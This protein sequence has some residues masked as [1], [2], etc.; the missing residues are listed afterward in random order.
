MNAMI[1]ITKN[2][3]NEA[4]DEMFSSPEVKDGIRF[5]NV[6]KI[7]IGARLI[8]LEYNE[9]DQLRIRAF[10]R[11]EFRT[12]VIKDTEDAHTILSLADLKRFEGKY[13]MED[14]DIEF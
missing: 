10:G 3:I 13:P 14:D 11:D 4:P 7:S 9:D 8:Y 2:Q 5:E 1:Y 12:V 6:T